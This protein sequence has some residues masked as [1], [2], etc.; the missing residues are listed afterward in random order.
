[1]NNFQYYL[2]KA[3]ALFNNSWLKAILGF[4]V[5]LT[6]LTIALAVLALAWSVLFGKSSV[7]FGHS[8]N[9]PTFISKAPYSGGVVSKRAAYAKPGIESLGMGSPVDSLEV[10]P[11]FDEGS[12]SDKAE[13]YEKVSYSAHY[14]DSDIDR[15]CNSI[16]NLKALD[17]VVFTYARRN[18]NYCNYNFWTDKAHE[19]EVVRKL[20]SLDPKEFNISVSSLERSI[21]GSDFEIKLLQEEMDELDETIKEAKN[22]YSDLIALAKNRG[23]VTDLTLIIDNKIRLLERLQS[24]KRSLITRLERLQRR[25]SE[26]LDETQKVSFNVSLRKVETVDLEGIK[27]SWREYTKSFIYNLNSYLKFFSYDLLLFAIKVLGF[28]VYLAVVLVILRLA[29]LL[30]R[31]IW[32]LNRG[33]KLFKDKKDK[34][35]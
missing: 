12:L 11:D 30:A 20:K 10:L 17:Y 5:L 22:A 7:R 31:K 34:K 1:M 3:K 18:K 32:K 21:S 16:E 33:R 28:V 4:V 25:N 6:A 35:K 24:K 23:K 8:F 9:T 29:Y 27:E 19:E 26:T 13:D 15:K 14:E 2:E